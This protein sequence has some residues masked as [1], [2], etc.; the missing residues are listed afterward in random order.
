MTLIRWNP[1]RE[2]TAWHP[3]LEINQGFNQLQR[4]IDRMLDHVRSGDRD[5]EAMKIWTPSVDIVE[6]ENN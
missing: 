4:E 3:A 5:E 1:L 2:V 6:N